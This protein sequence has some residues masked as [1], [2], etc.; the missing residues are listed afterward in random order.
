MFVSGSAR[1]EASRVSS[2]GVPGVPRTLPAAA[3]AAGPPVNGACIL[4]SRGCPTSHQGDR[5]G[6]EERSG[7][8]DSK[9]DDALHRSWLPRER[10][11][12]RRKLPRVKSKNYPG[13]IEK[14]GR[15][16]LIPSRRPSTPLRRAS[17]VLR[18]PYRRSGLFE[19]SCCQDV[20]KMQR[21]GRGRHQR[22]RADCPDHRE[23]RP[24]REAHG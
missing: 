1:R 12:R 11:A 19:L 14:K 3:G 23:A 24:R 6:P 9:A 20:T 21:R 5:L 22:R 16:P 13:H 2:E 4:K 10:R 17:N 15:R 8:A 18:A 7:V